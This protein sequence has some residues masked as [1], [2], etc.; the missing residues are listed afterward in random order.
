MGLCADTPGLVQAWTAKAIGRLHG[1][2]RVSDLVV[3]TFCHVEIAF[4][5]SQIGGEQ[6]RRLQCT[7]PSVWETSVALLMS[8]SMCATLARVCGYSDFSHAVW[9]QKVPEYIVPRRCIV[10]CCNLGSAVE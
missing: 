5:L 4:S 1:V 2:S 10:I 8:A 6:Q 9:Y 3:R 7:F